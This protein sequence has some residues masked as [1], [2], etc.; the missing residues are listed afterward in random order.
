ML[1][2]FVFGLLMLLSVLDLDAQCSMCKAV[3]ETN[4]QNGEEAVGR[5]IN[6]GII[7][8]MFVPY[9]LL[10]VVGYFMY[11]HYVKTNVE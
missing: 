4:M 7:Y 6:D 5:G 8:I 9:L 10:G 1:A 11:K 2:F 3:L